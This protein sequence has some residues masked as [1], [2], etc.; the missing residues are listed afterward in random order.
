VGDAARRPVTVSADPA[1]SRDDLPHTPGTDTGSALAE[2]VDDEGMRKPAT[3]AAEVPGSGV[4]LRPPSNRVSNRAVA[5]WFT[6]A[7]LGWLAVVAVQAVAWLFEWPIPP[8]KPQ[9]LAVT[10]VL[11]IAHVVVMPRWRYRVHRWELTADAVYT[12]SG[13]WTQ[14]WRIAP[15]SRIQTVDTVR[16]PIGRLFRL[17]KLTVTTAS[18]AG[19]LV[20]DGLDEPV[21]AELAAQIT[22]AAGASAGDAT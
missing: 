18:A 13:W 2:N 15:L 4:R 19:P 16:G 8:W 7:L 6:R 14:E 17:T 10:V 5:Y 3:T 9:V 1:G 21:A 12:R 11:A 20:I 22:A